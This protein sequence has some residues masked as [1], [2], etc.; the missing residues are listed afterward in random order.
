VF[1]ARKR[2][3]LCV[4]DYNAPRARS[5][6]K[7]QC[8]K[9]DWNGK[10]RAHLKLAHYNELAVRDDRWSEAIAVGSL[11]FVEKIK[12]ELGIKALHR[13]LE[14]MGAAYALREPSESYTSKCAGENDALTPEN[15]VLWQ[16]NGE[17]AGT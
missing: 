8:S 17:T 10:Q 13:E 7:V 14:P 6:F 1:E 12:S 5:M 2:F 11:A 15:T 9:S 3:G 4:L 16:E